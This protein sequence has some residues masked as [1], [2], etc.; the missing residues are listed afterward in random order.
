VG[1]QQP[2]GKT[3]HLLGIVYTM[4]PCACPLPG[5]PLLPPAH[6]LCPPFSPALPGLD[7]WTFEVVVMLSGLLDHP[8]Q[9]M[10]MMGITNIH[11]HPPS[12]FFPTLFCCL[13]LLDTLFSC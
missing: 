1:A 11:P 4:F 9:T 5:C 3:R 7:W 12:P 10:S 13:D 8:E 6:T 2:C